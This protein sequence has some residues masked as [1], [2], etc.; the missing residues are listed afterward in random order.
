MGY[1]DGLYFRVV[2]QRLANTLRVYGVTPLKG[3]PPGIYPVGVQ[4]VG[5]PV[6]EGTGAG[7][8]HPVAGRKGINH[9]CLQPARARR[10]QDEQVIFR[11]KDLL[12]HLSALGYQLEEL[13][14]P[15]VDHGVRHGFINLVGDGRRP[16]GSQIMGLDP[17]SSSWCLYAGQLSRQPNSLSM[18]RFTRKMPAQRWAYS[19]GL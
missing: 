10:S 2:S 13:G 11:H 5:E 3:N 8:Q 17:H 7:C 19:K 16:G 15:V 18:C 6:A 12:Q 9:R 4:H 14:S 1:D